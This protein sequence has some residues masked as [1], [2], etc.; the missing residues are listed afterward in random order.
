M[1][2]ED[3]RQV[4]SSNKRVKSKEVVL[5]VSIFPSLVLPFLARTI[6]ALQIIRK[7]WEGSKKVKGNENN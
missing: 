4:G 2:F 1:I 5:L 6:E 3:W 7:L